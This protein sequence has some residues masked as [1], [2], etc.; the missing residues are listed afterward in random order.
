MPKSP[1]ETLAKRGVP[2]LVVDVDLLD[3]A[4]L[5]AVRVDDLGAEDA[6]DGVRVDHG[7]SFRSCCGVADV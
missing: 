6:V 1:V 5:L 3:G 4:H 7:R 2:V